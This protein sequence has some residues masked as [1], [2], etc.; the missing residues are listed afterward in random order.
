MWR[1]LQS[2]GPWGSFRRCYTQMAILEN[3]VISCKHL[4]VI[5]S[6]IMCCQN[7][8]GGLCIFRWMQCYVVVTLT[9]PN[10]AK[11]RSFVRSHTTVKIAKHKRQIYA[12]SFI[13]FH[14][15]EWT[16]TVV[17]L[18]ASPRSEAMRFFILLSSSLFLDKL[19]GM[20]LL[21]Q[22]LQRHWNWCDRAIAVWCMFIHN[23]AVLIFNQLQL[24]NCPSF[25]K[26]VV[27]LLGRFEWVNIISSILVWGASIW[28]FIKMSLGFWR[29]ARMQRQHD[30]TNSTDPENICRLNSKYFSN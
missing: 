22:Y 9:V 7:T 12:W 25:C 13:Q 23:K 10:V 21:E 14:L 24:R 20:C 8:T 1:Q 26:Q 17:I 2:G 30:Q 16:R 3:V 11:K 28:M 15:S 27:Q 19:E 5:G 6:P 18:I 4:Q 29:F